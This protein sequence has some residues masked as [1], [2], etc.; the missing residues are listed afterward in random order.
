VQ[1]LI[2]RIETLSDQGRLGP[3]DFE[4]LV[5]R[6]ETT[7][8]ALDR[9]NHT[10][11]QNA[12]ESFVST[13]STLEARGTLQ[14]SESEQLIAAANGVIG[15]LRVLEA[16]GG[17]LDA[18]ALSNDGTLATLAVQSARGSAIR[19]TFTQGQSGWA[20]IA[21]HDVAGRLVASLWDGWLPEGRHEFLCSPCED[22]AAM[23]RGIYLVTARR[24]N[25]TVSRKL[26]LAR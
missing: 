26:V 5:R 15:K 18:P 1:L 4:S 8:H 21:I 6:L 25:A 24:R 19:V 9:G 14:G 20:E 2:G 22:T 17:E 12:L 10:V 3:D 7:L 11:A 13:V 23:A 16:E